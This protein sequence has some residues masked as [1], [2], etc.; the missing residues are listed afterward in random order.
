[1]LKEPILNRI[2]GQSDSKE[3]FRQ[4]EISYLDESYIIN[5]SSAFHD[6]QSTKDVLFKLSKGGF[7]L[8]LSTMVKVMKSDTMYP[9]EL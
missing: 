5:I 3:A 4:V 7:D 6:G 9:K 1:M 2:V 8:L